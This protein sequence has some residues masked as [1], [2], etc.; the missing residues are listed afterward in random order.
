LE[1]QDQQ[2]KDIKAYYMIPSSATT[3]DSLP[4]EIKESNHTITKF[5][6]KTPF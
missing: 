1:P 4:E 3:I 5:H 6:N 2:D